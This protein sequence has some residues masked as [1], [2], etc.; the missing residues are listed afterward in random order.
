MPR[1]INEADYDGYIKTEIK[2]AITGTTDGTPSAAQVRAE[3][4]AIATITEYIGGRY[5]CAAI[6]DTTQEVQARNKFMVACVIKLALY[7]LYHQT[8]VKDV[9]EHRKVEYDDTIQWL[10][11]AGR[12]T[13]KTTLPVL[14]AAGQSNEIWFESQK[15][16]RHK[17]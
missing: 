3:D 9:P 17:W 11:D 12:G 14:E 15:R 13:I 5:N 6:F 8:G 16:R 7:D 4:T 2:K 1:F 10:K